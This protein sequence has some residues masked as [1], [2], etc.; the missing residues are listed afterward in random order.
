[1]ADPVLRHKPDNSLDFRCTSEAKTATVPEILRR[2]ET[3]LPCVL[4][5][6]ARERCTKAHIAQTAATILSMTSIEFGQYQGKPFKWL[7]END[8]GWVTAILARYEQERSRM[9]LEK[10]APFTIN[11]EAFREYCF[12]Y[13]QVR[14]A[15]EERVAMDR[16][17][18]DARKTGDMGSSLV[19]FGKYAKLTFQELLDSKD[20]KGYVS[21]LL[22]PHN[23]PTSGSRMEV[24]VEWIRKQKGKKYYLLILNIIYIPTTNY[25]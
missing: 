22:N 5:K 15:V 12:L 2:K 14:E 23:K 17:E 6:E 7:L 16:Q 25:L 10:P 3:R 18:L 20:A 11:R 19:N 13:P 4:E 9:T 21:Y 24:L 1:M 8:L